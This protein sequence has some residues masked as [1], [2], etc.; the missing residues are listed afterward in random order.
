METRS[1]T[2][3]DKEIKQISAFLSLVFPNASHF[4]EAFIRW[5][6]LENPAGK[7]IGCNAYDGGLLIGHY[8]TVPIAA[9]VF[10]K[11]TTGV[12]SLN[13]ATHP[14]YGGKGIFTNLAHQVYEE[15]KHQGHEF[16]IGVANQN[17]SHGFVK[18]LGFQLVTPLDVRVGFGN[19]ERPKAIEAVE[20]ELDFERY[21][22]KEHWNWRVQNPSGRYLYEK[23]KTDRAVWLAKTTVPTLRAV[24]SERDDE[25]GLHCGGLHCG[26]LSSLA[27]MRP[28]VWLGTDPLINWKSG[29]WINL[30]MKL[31]PSPLNLIFRDLSGKDRTLQ[32]SRVR[33]WTADFDAY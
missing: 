14:N 22:S 30:P 17:S 27:L 21:W 19:I 6:Y 7:A 4:S 16:V 20:Q 31:R 33:F 29:L 8:V 9:K 24:L 32:K 12:L 28:R 25:G 1:L 10:G 2:N 15:A 23:T 5:L 11:K 18:K 26:R 3:T 13:T